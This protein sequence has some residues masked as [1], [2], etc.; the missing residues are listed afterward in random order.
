MKVGIIGCGFVLDKYM[1]TWSKYP[2]LEIAGVTD[3]DRGRVDVVTRHYGHESYAENAALLADPEI[4]IV[5]NFTSI[6]AHYEVTKAAL[7]AGKHVYSEKPLVP[8]MDQAR[9]LFALAESRGLR[10]SCAPSIVLGAT[11]QT[12]WKAVAD[13]AIG[14]ARVAYAEFDTSP[15][16]LMRSD[17]P[18]R[19]TD[20]ASF[21]FLHERYDISASGA[22][23]P[24][25]HEFEAGC[26]YEHSGYHLSWMCAM[27]GP[28]KS[29]TAF[30]KQIM[31]DKTDRPLD[32]PDTPDF[33]VAT[34]DFHSGV[35]GRITCSIS[36]ANDSRMRI[37]GTR[38]MLNAYTYGNYQCP[39]YLEPFNKLTIKARYFRGLETN[40]FL[41]WLF[42]VGGRRVPLVDPP[43]PGSDR[44]VKHRRRW[45]D[46]REGLRPLKQSILGQQDKV[47]G[48]AEL[49]DA[50][51]KDRPQFPSHA[52]SL[53]LT[54]LTLAISAAG[55]QSQ[56]HILETTFDR[57]EVPE[58]TREAGID[59]RDYL[60]PP[61]LG[62]I[63]AGILDREKK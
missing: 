40:L 21:P 43:S 8:R 45:W 63:A 5:C 56:A 33:S 34:L 13:G 42:G 28:V 2:G 26:T 38:G 4:D 1:A 6:P 46:V 53:H 60:R 15:L 18:E 48:I 14:D 32:P 24:F 29:V 47:I 3:I 7:E 54:E 58:R 36:G 52:F 25:L 35:V 11:S 22:P 31:A 9:E 27:F 62:R 16:Y 17:A 61:L 59:Y 44:T 23:F 50:I 49:A 41:H 12:L 37:I 39:V 30:S 55:T 10:L 57:L 19:P 51:A 20:G